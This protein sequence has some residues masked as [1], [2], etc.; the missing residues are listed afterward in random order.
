[1]LIRNYKKNTKE[2]DLEIILKEVFI[3]MVMSKNLVQIFLQILISR[4]KIQAE[5]TKMLQSWLR[6]IQI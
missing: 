4:E 2:T 6:S 1:M 3:E 5:I